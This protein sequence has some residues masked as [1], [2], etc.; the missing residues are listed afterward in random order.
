MMQ[1][2]FEFFN[3]LNGANFLSQLMVKRNFEF[4]FFLWG[5]F[6][7]LIDGKEKF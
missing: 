4:R 7:V 6:F 2:N 3:L 5:N 1:R